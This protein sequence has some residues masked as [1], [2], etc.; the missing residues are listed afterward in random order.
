MNF[1]ESDSHTFFKFKV[2]YV[3]YFFVSKKKDL[4]I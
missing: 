3:N 1:T 2:I 4:E